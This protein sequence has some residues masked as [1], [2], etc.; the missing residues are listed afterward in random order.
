[1]AGAD[2]R[3]GQRA[4]S[5]HPRSGAARKLA[6][7]PALWPCGFAAQPRQRDRRGWPD[8][9]I[10][11]QLPPQP[12]E[13][14]A[15][16]N[17]LLTAMGRPGGSD[18]GAW[19]DE[20]LRGKESNLRRLPPGT[21]GGFFLIAP[22]A[23]TAWRCQMGVRGNTDRPAAVARPTNPDP[24]HSSGRSVARG[25]LPKIHHSII[26]GTSILDR[27]Q[28]AQ[29]RLAGELN[30][31]LAGRRAR[32]GSRH[33]AKSL[34]ELLCGVAGGAVPIPWAYPRRSML[35]PCCTESPGRKRKPWKCSGK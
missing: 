16:S 31:A 5:D 17:G 2:R 35:R 24:R 22:Y 19:H 3:P 30:L 6:A 33:I 9:L 1:M 12:S 15:A 32:C 7:R 34:S 13:H 4:P 11:Y 28:N 14:D 26:K 25:L 29:R 21:P 10:A 27:R 23:R 8:L 20:A 18:E